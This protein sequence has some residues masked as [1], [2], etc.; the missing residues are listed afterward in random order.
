MAAP[1]RTVLEREE[2][3]PEIERLHNAGLSLREIGVRF[4][5]STRIVRRDLGTIAQR[6]RNADLTERNVGVH[7]AIAALRMVRCE[8][9]KAWF[10]SKED[11][12]RDIEE[13][14]GDTIR[15]TTITEGRVGKVEHLLTILRTLQEEAK[16]CGLYAPMQDVP[17]YPQLPRSEIDNHRLEALTDQ[18]ADVESNEQAKPQAEPGVA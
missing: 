8:A 1:K 15:T 5:L 16:L 11:W 4:G 17:T 3:L 12:V 2:Q 14:V 10:R 7:R 6:Y 9:F 13:K 18:P